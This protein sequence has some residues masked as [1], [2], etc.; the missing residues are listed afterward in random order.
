ML[1]LMVNMAY[2]EVKFEYTLKGSVWAR[3]ILEI[4]ESKFE[5]QASYTYCT[6]DQI[7]GMAVDVL[8]HPAKEGFNNRFFIIDEEWRKIEFHFLF[9]VGQNRIAKFKIIEKIE[10]EVNTEK[11]VYTDTIDYYQFIQQVIISATNILRKFGLTGYS[12][13]CGG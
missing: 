5:Y 1:K 6:L 4:A 13:N 11:I 7:F 2:N 10:D 12:V 8:D 9:E 3:I